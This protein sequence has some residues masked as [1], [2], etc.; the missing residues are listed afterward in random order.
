LSAAV[1]VV[2]LEHQVVL[3]KTQSVV[4]VVLVK[5]EPWSG[6]L[7]HQLPDLTQHQLQR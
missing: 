7:L 5:A 6:Y 4:V 2:V 3:V 1:V